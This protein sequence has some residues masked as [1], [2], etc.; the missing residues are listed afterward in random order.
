MK[1]ILGSQS[2]WRKR[3]LT[4][5]GIQIDAQ[6]SPDINEKAI[7]DTDPE[8]LVILLANAKADALMDKITE[9]ALLIT[10]DQ[11]IFS[12]GEIR[13]KPVDKAEAE[14]FLLSYI[15]HPAE[16]V[17]GIVVTNTETKKRFSGVAYGGAQYKPTLTESIQEILEEPNVMECAG[18]LF[19][20][21]PLLQ[22][23][24][25][26]IKGTQDIFFGV[27]IELLKKLMKEAE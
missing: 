12:N 10:G 16:V 27:P 6:M 19:V 5:A 17:N 20:E 14:K 4:E 24:E 1:I 21:H 7:R 11:V 13:E 3:A 25:L 8:K 22:K 2:P 26:M 9:P 18:A 15:D 23:H